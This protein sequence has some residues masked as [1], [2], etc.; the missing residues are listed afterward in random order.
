MK[1][2]L[3]PRDIEALKYIAANLRE[4]DKVELFAT[5]WT[6]NTDELAVDTYNAG[7]FQWIAWRDG[8]P[9]AVVGAVAMWPNV[10][11]AFAYGTDRW[12]EA[13]LTLTKLVRRVMIPTL[14]GLGAH[15]VQCH[16][17]SGHDDARRWLEALGAEVENVIPD[18]GLNQEP[19]VLYRW[20]RRETQHVPATP[21]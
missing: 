2:E 21:R 4:R 8:T 20:R 9:V 15:R 12:P 7:E 6:T 19:F 13:V 16:A 1:T 10:W 14:E 5:R 18:Y 3:G 11:S 17:Y